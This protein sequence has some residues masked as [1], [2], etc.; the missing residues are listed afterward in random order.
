MSTSG[1][2]HLLQTDSLTL[3]GTSTLDLANNDAIVHGGNLGNLT[4]SLQTG[5]AGGAWNGSGITSSAAA[6]NSTHLTALGVTQ[7]SAAGTFDGAAVAAGDVL[8]KYTYYG[9]ANLDGQVDGSDYS[10]IDN[11]S[12]QHLSGWSNGDFNYDGVV[13]GSDYTLI[14]NAFNTQGS[15][16]AAASAQSAAQIAGSSVPEPGSL[17]IL[18]AAAAGLLCRRRARSDW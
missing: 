5:Y 15:P 18:F 16:I 12:L 9:D 8:I 14:D 6:T 13:N 3:A 1:T 11:G 4:A 2:R 17:S 7:A 10:K